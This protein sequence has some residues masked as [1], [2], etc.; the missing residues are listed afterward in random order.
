MPNMRAVEYEGS[1]AAARSASAMARLVLLLLKNAK[2]RPDILDLFRVWA[3]AFRN[4]LAA[5]DG[6]RALEAL[7]RYTLEVSD[8]VTPQNIAQVLGSTV[9]DDAKEAVTTAAQRLVE[10]GIEQ[11]R[12][13]GQAHAIIQVLHARGI[14]LS[15]EQRDFIE[16]CGDASRLAEWLRRAV[17]VE[18]MDHF[19]D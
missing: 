10:Q 13:L 15:N 2:H 17:H 6:L 7:V 1:D 9:G 8:H 3:D 11:G 12:V 5:P 16:Y 19:F 4:V 14:A 18:S